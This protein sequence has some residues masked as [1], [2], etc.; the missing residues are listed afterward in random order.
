MP[1]SGPE[2][3]SA[4]SCAA[5]RFHGDLGARQPHSPVSAARLGGAGWHVEAGRE[6]NHADLK[7]SGI[8]LIRRLIRS[9]ASFGVGIETGRQRY[10]DEVKGHQRMKG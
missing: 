3:I 1:E 2:L 5:S 4:P 9:L 6:G 7:N 10:G 8:K